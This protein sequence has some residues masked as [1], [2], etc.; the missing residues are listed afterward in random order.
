MLDL[1]FSQ[2]S[3]IILKL[4]LAAVLGGIL[5]L[6]R[7]LAGK[8]AGVRTYSL[9]SLGACLFSLVPFLIIANFS[10]FNNLVGVG[11]D[12]LRMASQVVVG[13]GF[14]GAGLII[15]HEN[16]VRGL[17]TAAELWVTAAIG[18]AVS[19]GFYK[20]AAVSALLVLIIVY[21]AG[22]LRLEEKF[23]RQE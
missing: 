22:R 11:F 2:N 23:N 16:K 1:L 4:V 13:V 8:E 7:E 6:E 17:T 5:G 19:F 9:V 14:I 12:P 10:D 21:L 15:F 20:E 3:E 18:T